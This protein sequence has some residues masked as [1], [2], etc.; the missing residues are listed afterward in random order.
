MT[1]SLGGSVRKRAT[2]REKRRNRRRIGAAG[3][4]HLPTGYP[5][6]TQLVKRLAVE[7]KVQNVRRFTGVILCAAGCRPQ[8]VA[9]FHDNVLRAHL[10]QPPCRITRSRHGVDA[11]PA[12]R[13]G[14]RK[15][16]RDDEH[17]RQKL[18][19]ERL[20]AIRVEQPCAARRGEHGVEDD[21]RQ[22]QV[23]DRRGD[24][25]GDGSRSEHAY[26]GRLNLRVRR[27]RLDLRG[28][29]VCGERRNRRDPLGILRGDRRDGCGS[30]DAEGLECSKVGLDAGTAARIAPGNCQRT[31]HTLSL[32]LMRTTLLDV[33]IARPE[34]SRAVRSL[35]RLGAVLFV[36]VLTIVAAQI[37]IPLPFTPVPFTFQPMVVLVG[38]AVLGARLGAA[39]QA[40][41][42]A[43]GVT[44][45]PVFAASALL[46][47]GAARLLGPTGG[48]LLA[49]PI[50]A[51][52]AGWL[53][54]RGF[55]RRYATAVLA[56]VCGL[57][58]VFAGGV[59]WLVLAPLG[60]SSG[61]SGALAAGFYPFIAADLLKLLVA[62][63]VMPSLWRL[64]GGR[65]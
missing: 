30:A 48:Y 22:L 44:G 6:D 9:A 23:L 62:A 28:D 1:L 25:F 18:G 32:T 17:A 36:T 52:V 39:A 46:P 35:Q 51:F 40:L 64:T 8:A 16:R 34:D 10:V 49:Y 41:Y 37:S 12:E 2:K 4:S 14:L 11:Y 24:R 19:Y 31:G 53:A 61:W 33:M 57:A 47:Q 5:G 50:A 65:D 20:D 54:E 55:D 15:I 63:A 60:R 56:M 27:N 59:S 26:L 43:L 21:E 45:L 29:E 38:A 13:L 7:Q 58:V 3:P 42:L